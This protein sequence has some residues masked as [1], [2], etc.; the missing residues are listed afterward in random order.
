MIF[1]LKCDETK[2]SATL[3]HI[4]PMLSRE[5]VLQNDPPQCFPTRKTSNFDHFHHQRDMP[6]LHVL[7]LARSQALD[8]QLAMFEMKVWIMC[9]L[10]HYDVR[11]G[12]A[13]LVIIAP[14]FLRNS[15]GYWELGGGRDRAAGKQCDHAACMWS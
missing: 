4:A 11:P 15:F 8:S 10:T 6:R 2:L 7:E 14:V 9:V 3:R 13:P 12:N 1:V 5:I